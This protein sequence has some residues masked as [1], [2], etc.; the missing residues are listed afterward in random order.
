MPLSTPA[1][2]APVATRPHDASSLPSGVLDEALAA[3]G[4]FAALHVSADGLLLDSAGALHRDTAEAAAAALTAATAAIRGCGT[5][6]AAPGLAR[7]GLSRFC[8][9]FATL[10]LLAQPLADG[11]LVALAGDGA[12]DLAAMDLALSDVAAEVRRRSSR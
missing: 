8:G 3:A 9:E 5:A 1:S 6:I 2:P 10:T 7:P 11:S 12:A 4:V